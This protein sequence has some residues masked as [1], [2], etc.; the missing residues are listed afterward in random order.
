[1]NTHLDDQ[2]SR[3][4]KEAARIILK[5]IDLITQQGNK[6]HRSPLILA[7]DFNSTP[8]QEAYIEMTRAASPMHDLQLITP[9]EQIYGD[10]N[11]YSGFDPK[12]DKRKRIDFIFIN[13]KVS[14]REIRDRGENTVESSTWLANGYAVLP[15]TFEDKIYISDHQ[16]VIGDVAIV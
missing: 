1:M 5:H 14:N 15:N 9:E 7:G 12:K 3:S 6:A 13:G 16:V 2:G 4:R 8:D 11:T 10:S